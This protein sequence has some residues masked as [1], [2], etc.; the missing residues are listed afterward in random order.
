MK[1][2]GFLEEDEWKEIIYYMYE[3]EDANYIHNRILEHCKK[4]HK[5]GTELK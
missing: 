3:N 2:N 5:K 4:Q 1:T